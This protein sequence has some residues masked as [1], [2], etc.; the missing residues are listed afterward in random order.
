M[1]MRI[2]Y[3]GFVNQLLILIVILLLIPIVL[4][5]YLFHMVHS[6][7]MG[8]INNQRKVLEDVL[9]HLDK[10]LDQPFD[11]TLAGLKVQSLPKRDQ[12]KALNHALKP[13]IDQASKKY[14]GIDMGYYS[15]D[16]DVI[17][18]GDNQH[19][20]ENFSV[21]RKRNFDDALETK[22]LVFEVL[23]QSENGQLEAYRPLVRD[24][25]VIGA[26]WAN[27]N[28]NQ[29]YRTVGEIQQVVYVI[30]FIGALLAF[31]GAF[32]LINNFARSV[33][34]I[35]KGL[36]AMGN[37]PTYIIPRV[38]GELGEITDAV[39]EMFN[40]LTDV[41]HYNELIL[42]SLEDGIITTD[43]DGKIISI[44]P[45]AGRILNLNGSCLGRQISEVL[46]EDS[47]FVYYLKKIRAENKP[48]KDLDVIYENAAEETRQF[49][50]STSSMVNVRGERVG[51]LLHFRDITEMVQ[52]QESVHRQQRLASLGKLVAGVAHEIRSPLTSINGYMQFWSKGHVPSTKSLNI[53]NRELS[54]L[55]SMTDK[56]LEF[57]RPSRAVFEECDINGLVKRLVQFFDDAHG[58]DMEISYAY[59]ENLPPAMIDWSQIEQVLSNILYNAYQATDGKGKLD[60]TTD[61]DVDRDML[62]VTVK[63][64]GCGIPEEVIPKMFE[65]FFSTKSK[66]T[67]LGLA[68]AFEI[69]EAHNGFIQVESQIGE[70][71]TVKIYL[72]SVNR[73]E[74]HAARAYS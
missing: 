17:L 8:M 4:T 47:P 10:N 59:R 9:D 69:M 5:L 49:L 35:K 36:N 51:T 57:A 63:D 65:P 41:Q 64:N 43:W 50:L 44:N 54:R 45:A 48:V 11:S 18:D 56:L 25:K 29:I 31:S 68:I 67:G 1:K 26:V 23:G 27:K 60:I 70:G 37:D 74:N 13:I 32:M 40:K 61:Y 30:I 62:A 19:L 72:P 34:D 20:N 52:L 58:G 55:S 12:I 7:E 73:G 24:G 38:S 22:N 53:V 6:T 71:T 16:F 33:S 15:R 2:K 14:P 39:N 46:D 3:E 28:I 66:G 42:T 21:R